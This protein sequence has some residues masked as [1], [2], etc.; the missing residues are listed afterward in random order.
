[1]YHI[2]TNKNWGGYIHIKVDFR[3]ENIIRDSHF[4][5]NYEVAFFN[6]SCCHFYYM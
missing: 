6:L 1:M 5:S 4:C 3:E 2:N